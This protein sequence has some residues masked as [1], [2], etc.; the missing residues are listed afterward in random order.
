MFQFSFLDKLLI[1]SIAWCSRIL[2]NKILTTREII[3][4]ASGV[5]SLFII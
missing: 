4:Y 2:V 5:L 3:L 1:I